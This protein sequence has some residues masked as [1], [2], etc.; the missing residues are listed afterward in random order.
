[1]RFPI[2]AE[3][4]AAFIGPLPDAADVVVVGGAGPEFTHERLSRVY[5]WL[6]RGIPVVAMHRSLMWST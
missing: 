6:C 1:M 3:L 2:R 5:D 4:P